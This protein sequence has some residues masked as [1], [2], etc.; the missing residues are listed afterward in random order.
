MPETIANPPNSTARHP[1]LNAS[2]KEVSAPVAD[3][4]TLNK[5]CLNQQL[6][7]FLTKSLIAL[8]MVVAVSLRRLARPVSMFIS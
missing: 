5:I 8:A 7:V 3:K 6:E 2:H 1:V 4:S